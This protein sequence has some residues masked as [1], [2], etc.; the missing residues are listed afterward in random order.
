VAEADPARP[1][2]NGTLPTGANA[3][4]PTGANPINPP[5]DPKPA[6][7][8]KAT[9]A[10]RTEAPAAG[11]EPLIALIFELAEVARSSTEPVEARAHAALALVQAFKALA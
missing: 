6:E 8:P 1:P 2:A 5:D 10:K 11:A 4:P 9:R 7:K 3:T